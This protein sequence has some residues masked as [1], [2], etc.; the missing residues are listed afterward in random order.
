MARRFYLSLCVRA[1]QAL[2]SEF[3]NNFLDESYLGDGRTSI[4]QYLASQS[5]LH[6]I[7][8]LVDEEESQRIALLQAKRSPEDAK[9]DNYAV[10]M[11]QVSMA[12]EHASNS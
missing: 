6:P 4:R 5:V 11:Q 1:A 9:R 3:V 12:G 7:T 8:Y 10:D 2:G